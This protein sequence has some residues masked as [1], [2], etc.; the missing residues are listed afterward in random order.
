MPSQ[1]KTPNYGL[2]QWVETEAPSMG[3][4]NDAMQKL[5][6]IMGVPVQP[7]PNSDK[8]YM[9]CSNGILMEWGDIAATV[10]LTQTYGSLYHNTDYVSMINPFISNV[11]SSVQIRSTGIIAAVDAYYDSA[12]KHLNF[13]MLSPVSVSALQIAEIYFAIGRWK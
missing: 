2:P 4:F 12:T 7:D 11:S 6:G 13:T 3:D 1:M 8:W 9:K 5:D 10:T